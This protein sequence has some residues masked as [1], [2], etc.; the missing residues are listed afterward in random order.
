M[1]RHQD[2]AFLQHIRNTTRI[3]RKPF[4]GIVSGYHKL[5]YI[6]I[7]PDAN[8]DRNSVEI[9]GRI[10][11]SPRLVLTPDMNHPTFKELFGEEIMDKTLT[12][13]VFSFLYSGRYSN[14]KVQHEDLKINRSEDSPQ[15]KES[16]VMDELLRREIVDT[17]LIGCPNIEYYPISLERFIQEI[18]DREFN[19]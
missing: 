11:V 19:L 1:S 9:R 8:N 7:G 18:M 5:P 12:A 3:L 10:H 2:P 6:L 14:L 15:D 16:H 17:A 4:T 13:R